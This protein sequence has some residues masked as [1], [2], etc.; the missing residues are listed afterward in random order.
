MQ[1]STALLTF[2]V[3]L[4]G[5]NSIE[6]RI[7]EDPAEFAALPKGDQDRVR[8][9][10]IEVGFTPQMVRWAL[11][12]PTSTSGDPALNGTWTFRS[13]HRDYNDLVRA[14]YR[15]RIVFDPVRRGDVIITEP[16]DDRQSARL[17][18]YSLRVIFSDNRVAAI[19]RVPE[20]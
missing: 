4:A 12:A 2:A 9:G 11:G 15:R 8:S 10:K 6:S 3:L 1:A 13:F 17:E 14:G 19:E 18:P 7:R 16:I 5:C 20:I